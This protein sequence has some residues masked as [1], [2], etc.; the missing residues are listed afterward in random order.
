METT[1]EPKDSIGSKE[2]SALIIIQRGILPLRTRLESLDSYQVCRESVIKISDILD[3]SIPEITCIHERSTFN[4]YNQVNRL[5]LND[6]IS[7]ESQVLGI[8]LLRAYERHGIVSLKVEGDRFD[9]GC[10]DKI[11]SRRTLTSMLSEYYRK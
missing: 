2:H 8:E 4:T 11:N 5:F 10:W 1:C 6:K 3:I 9:L 7:S